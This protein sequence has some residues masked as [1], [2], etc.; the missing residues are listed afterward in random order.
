MSQS[1]TGRIAIE[2]D[3]TIYTALEMKNRL[4]GAIDAHQSAEVDLSGVTDMDTAG[5]QLMILAKREATRRDRQLQ[6]V[7]HSQAVT[8][9]LELCNMASY[10]GD[11]ILLSTH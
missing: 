8:E 2:G 5:L 1:E 9:V 11:P 6:Y 7:G 10:F 3:L 4:L